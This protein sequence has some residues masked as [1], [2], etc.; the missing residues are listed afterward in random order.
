[1][2]HRGGFGA[3]HLQRWSNNFGGAQMNAQDE[4][5]RSDEYRAT[6][7]RL[8]QLAEPTIHFNVMKELEQLHHAGAWDQVTGRSS[9]TLAKYADFRI[10]LISMK[11]N[12]RMDQHRADG[13]ISIQCLAGRL[14]VHLSA[15]RSA[16]MTVGGLLVLDFG[17]PHDVEALAESAFLLT[18]A[19]PDSR[20][21]K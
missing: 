15:E 13:R 2:Q 7:T 3:D 14:R 5:C 16:E 20:V 8:P 19:W 21:P 12:T 6:L 18:I 11:A 4:S 1:M 9:K 10:E 17:I